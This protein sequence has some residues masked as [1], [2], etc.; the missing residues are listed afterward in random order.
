MN[1]VPSSLLAGRARS[2][3]LFRLGLLASVASSASALSVPQRIFHPAAPPPVHVSPARSAA[4]YLVKFGATPLRFAPP[5]PEPTERPVPPEAI[6]PNVSSTSSTAQSGST[7]PASAE[8]GTP[9]PAEKSTQSAGNMVRIIPDDTPR[10]VRADDV[11]S[12]FQLPRQATAPAPAGENVP[13]AP[14]Q[15]AGSTL[16]PSSATYEQK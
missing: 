11:M 4:P 2:S 6:A 5:P 1:F 13:F 7:A 3:R 8:S 16:P 14:A 15:P 12:F 10:D 9:N